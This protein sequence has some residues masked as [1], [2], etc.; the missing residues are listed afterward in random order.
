MKLLG[1]SW[2]VTYYTTG[3]CDWLCLVHLWAEQNTDGGCVD[4]KGG[5]RVACWSHASLLVMK[6]VG[7]AALK[8]VEEVRRQLN[9]IPGLMEG[10]A[11]PDYATCV[12]ISTD[13]SS[14]L[15]CHAYSSH[16]WFLL[17]RW[18]PLWCPR[19]LPYLWSSG[20]NSYEP[21]NNS[22]GFRARSVRFL[23]YF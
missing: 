16:C 11:K 8:M 14:W 12:K 9:T 17:R 3:F 21:L 5:D 15:P 1:S 22:G 10:T 20:N 19:W 18:D 2:F 13:A 23:D 4:P 6:S 7:S